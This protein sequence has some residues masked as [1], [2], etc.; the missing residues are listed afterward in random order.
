MILAILLG[1]VAMFALPMPTYLLANRDV[2]PVGPDKEYSMKTMARATRPG[3]VYG[4]GLHIVLIILI[5]ISLNTEM[6]YEKQ[7]EPLFLLLIF[8][9]SVT[10]LVGIVSISF[11]NRSNYR[12]IFSDNGIFIGSKELS[13]L[14]YGMF[15]NCFIEISAY[16]M[17]RTMHYSLQI[18]FPGRKKL[19]FRKYFSGVFL[20]HIGIELIH[21]LRKNE[22]PFT[23]ENL[24]GAIKHKPISILK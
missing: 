11:T 15:K 20:K 10:N 8:V 16:A 1:V 7:M 12:L 24:D 17:T 13:F 2:V 18:T 23:Y 4:I 22:V 14:D 5:L 9:C 6:P 19:D 21:R 3:V